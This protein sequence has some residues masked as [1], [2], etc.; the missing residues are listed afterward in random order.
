MTEAQVYE[1][2]SEILRDVFLDDSIVARPTMTSRDV[3]G[4]DSFNNI[5]V[6]VGVE[7]RFGIKVKSNE[8]ET[9]KNVGELAQL[10]LNRTA[11]R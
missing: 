11:G 6:I 2:L 3:D 9:L 4:W 10:I 8:V 1:G 7:K 5:N